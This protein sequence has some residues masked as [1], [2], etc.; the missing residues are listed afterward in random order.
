MCPNRS[1]SQQPRGRVLVADDDPDTRFISTAALEHAGYEVHVA[2][3][4]LAAL[5]AIRH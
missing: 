5:A 2:A 3:D 1:D 4:G